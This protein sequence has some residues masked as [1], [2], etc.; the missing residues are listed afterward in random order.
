MRAGEKQL[1]VKFCFSLCADQISRKGLCQ[2]AVSVPFGF[3]L[4]L[5]VAEFCYYLEG[6]GGKTFRNRSLPSMLVPGT[7]I[8]SNLLKKKIGERCL[9]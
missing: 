1:S 7:F 3:L 6:R 4:R 9:L 2:S 5:V 8:F